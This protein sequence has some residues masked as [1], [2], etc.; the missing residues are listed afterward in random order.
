MDVVVAVGQTLAAVATG[1]LAFFTYRLARS[2]RDESGAVREQVEAA[3]RQVAASEAARQAQMMPWLTTC[4]RPLTSTSRGSGRLAP[5]G[6]LMSEAD[7]LITAGLALRNIGN[8]IALVED[9]R[10]FASLRRGTERRA[11]RTC[12][13]CQWPA[14]PVSTN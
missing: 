12:V 13:N 3:N 7:G 4:D 11:R 10:L 5:N 8:G 1:I 6:A 2:A 14:A 9:V